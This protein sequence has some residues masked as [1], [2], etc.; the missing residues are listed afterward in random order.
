M[1]DHP[2]E[3]LLKADR[4][5]NKF[6][7]S[8]ITVSAYGEIFALFL[9]LT[10]L[11]FDIS[12]VISYTLYNVCLAKR[13]RTS[14]ASG[15][16]SLPQTSP[17]SFY[18]KTLWLLKYLCN[19]VTGLYVSHNSAVTMHVKEKLFLRRHSVIGQIIHLLPVS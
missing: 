14:A 9:I 17:F 8:H 4:L 2:S 18:E 6:I 11:L 1:G 19:R 16:Y 7:K 3:E 13:E 12:S 10:K 15:N 5:W